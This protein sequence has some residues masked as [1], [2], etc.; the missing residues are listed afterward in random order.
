M[1]FV[2]RFWLILCTVVSTVAI[3]LLG[4]LG[5]SAFGQFVGSSEQGFIITELQA[6]LTAEWFLFGALVSLLLMALMIGRIVYV[7]RRVSAELQRIHS[8]SSYISLSTQLNSKHLYELSEPLSEL[9]ERVS[10]INEKQSLKMSAQHALISFLCANIKTPLLVTDVTGKILHVSIR[11]EEINN[12]ERSKLIDK[13]IENLVPNLFMHEVLGNIEV[14]QKYKKEQKEDLF[15]HVYPI[16][17][18]ASQITY[19]LFEIG[20]DSDLTYVSGGG[21]QTN[22]ANPKSDSFAKN[23]SKRMKKLLRVNGFPFFTGFYQSD[24][25][26]RRHKS[27][28]GEVD[29]EQ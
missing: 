27:S 16:Y 15:F 25:I 9:F 8:M 14:K 19:L 1:I 4:F 5:F 29:G 18:R 10:A 2:P 21:P 17:N 26:E 28:Q 12:T 11:Y 22:I 7:R 23:I 3:A 24:K 6:K 20:S 13:N